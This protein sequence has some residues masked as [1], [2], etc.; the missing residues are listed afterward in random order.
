VD[1][2][3]L[4]G[5]RSHGPATILST[6]STVSRL[7]GDGCSRLRKKPNHRCTPVATAPRRL[8]GCP[9]S[10]RGQRQGVRSP[11]WNR[12]AERAG[13]PAAELAKAVGQPV[14]ADRAARLSTREQ[15]GRRAL[16]TER[17]MSAAGGEQGRRRE[18]Q[19][20]RGA[21]RAQRRGEAAP[22]RRWSS[23]WARVRRL[24]VATSAR[25]AGRAGRQ[26]GPLL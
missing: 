8:C 21:R 7:R 3:G 12:A 22:D 23:T 14:G 10:A 17:G 4:C 20:A 9:A 5:W 6:V 26:R 1:N 24:I 25:R 2:S 19:A 18:W 11:S 13:P 16:I 15:P